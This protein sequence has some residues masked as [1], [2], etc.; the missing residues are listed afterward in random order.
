MS[1]DD[2]FEGIKEFFSGILSPAADVILD[3]VAS[4]FSTVFDWIFGFISG[5]LLV[6]FSDIGITYFDT[7]STSLAKNISNG[8]F[9]YFSI[10]ALITFPLL[11]IVINLIRG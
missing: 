10:G 3:F 5:D 1:I 7:I 9:M 6:K 11:K 4:G 2:L 8:Q